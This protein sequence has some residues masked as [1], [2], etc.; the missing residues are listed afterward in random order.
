MKITG[1]DLLKLTNQFGGDTFE[2]VVDCDTE[3]N[4]A[5]SYEPITPLSELNI[6]DSLIDQYIK[7]RDKRYY[8]HLVPGEF[9]YF[10]KN[11]SNDRYDWDLADNESDVN[12]KTEFTTA[13]I[14]ELC[15]KYPHIDFWAC[16]EEVTD[17]V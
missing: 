9:G 2:E 15:A 13:E 16:V 5:R 11:I 14:D 12:Y 3:G 7:Q 17:N 8:I 4:Y 10:I 1:E 6:P